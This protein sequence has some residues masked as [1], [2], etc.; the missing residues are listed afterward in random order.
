M[1]N[2]FFLTGDLKKAMGA[3]GHPFGI[4]H[5]VLLTSLTRLEVSRSRNR[6]PRLRRCRMMYITEHRGTRGILIYYRRMYITVLNFIYLK[7]A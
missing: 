6:R 3:V 2:A 7:R 4:M 5:R 1:S